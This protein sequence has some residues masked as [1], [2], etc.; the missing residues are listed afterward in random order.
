MEG[1]GERGSLKLGYQRVVE[2]KGAAGVD[3]LTVSELKDHLQRHWPTIRARLLAGDYWPMAV[4]RVDIRKPQGGMRTLGIPTVVDRLIQ[5]ALHQVLH[6]SSSRPSRRRATAF[7]QAGM[8]I[9]RYVERSSMWR[10]ASAGWWTSTW[11]AS[12]TGSTT[13]C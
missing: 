5:Q 9:R 3:E 7:G 6:R 4:R 11:S 8:R 13:I 2:N 12:S 1:V 10:A